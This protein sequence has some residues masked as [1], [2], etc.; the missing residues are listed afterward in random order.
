MKLSNG[1]SIR[2]GVRIAWMLT[3]TVFLGGGI[4]MVWW[5]AS[6]TIAAIQSQA[7]TLYD[8][9]SENDAEVR[10]A[11]ELRALG[12][13]VAEDVRA[14]SGQGS[15]SAVTA[16]ILGLLS[17][18][19][20]VFKID[21]R[22]IVPAPSTTPPR[23]EDRVLAG[24][25]IEIDARGQFRDLLAFVSDLPRHNVLIDLSDITLDD[26]DDRSLKPQVNAKIHATVFRYH[27]L[28]EEETP[29]ASRPL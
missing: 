7:K 28:A 27:G 5:P 9:A 17:R 14:L 24:A 1:L 21:V 22:S 19:A 20:R 10:R 16:T 15:Q 26:S 2:A 25:P 3:A 12:K 11:A 4:G 8:E 29:H 23:N 18:E 13:Q 6:Q